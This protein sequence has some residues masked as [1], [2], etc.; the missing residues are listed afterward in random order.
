MKILFQSR[1]DL[2]RN[3]G[4]DTFQMEHTKRMIEK[5]NP[6]VTVDIRPELKVK[7]IAHYDVVHLFNI[8]WICET[9]VQAKWAKKNNIPIILSAIHHSETEIKRYEKYYRFGIRRI[10]N[11]LVP[12]QSTK[13]VWKN[14]Y[15][16][17]I[18]R[19]YGKLRPTV[20]QLL[21]GIRN[22]QKE[23]IKMSNLVLVQTE[24]EAKDIKKDF[25]IDDFKW[26]KIV[27]GVNLDVFLKPNKGLFLDEVIKS[28][29]D[30]DY[31]SPILLSVGRIEPRKNGLNIIKAF[32]S[33]QKKN[34]LKSWK[35]IFIGALSKNHPEYSFRFK[36][37]VKRNVDILYLGPRSQGFVASAMLQKGVFVLPSWFETTGLSSLE[38]AMSGMVPVVSGERTKEYLG[39]NAEYCDPE[40]IESIQN[41]I[42]KASKRHGVSKD[43]RREIGTKYSWANS[44]IQ[45]LEVYKK[46]IQHRPHDK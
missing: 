26:K 46:L 29:K 15:R 31:K 9:Y 8:D 42:L 20:I 37:K 28:D 36:V 35:L 34:K 23:I 38:A 19:E 45:T 18:K 39:E 10:F 7:D 24:A 43:F 5:I 6:S 1:I 25:K 16:S 3:R 27:N 4:G 33:L 12:W 22:E 32:E 30:F 13:D 14:V 40:S 17:T 11:L 44:A 41:A 2:Y 21:K